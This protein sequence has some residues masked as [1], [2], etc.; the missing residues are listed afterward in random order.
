VSSEML[1]CEVGDVIPCTAPSLLERHVLNAI[2]LVFGVINFLIL[3]FSAFLITSF[4]L[5]FCVWN[6]LR[7]IELV[8]SDKLILD[9]QVKKFPVVVEILF[10]ISQSLSLFWAQLTLSTPFDS[11]LCKY[12]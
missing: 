2:D 4:K 6:C 11:I 10:T 7:G 3:R 5:A 12:I 9:C 1:S 8:P